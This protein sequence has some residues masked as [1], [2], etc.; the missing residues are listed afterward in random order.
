MVLTQDLI[1]FQKMSRLLQ[2]LDGK[3]RIAVVG[4]EGIP[5]GLDK[6]MRLLENRFGQP[7]IV[8]KACVDA[9]MDAQRLPTTIRFERIRRSSEIVVRN[10]VFNQRFG[11]D[12]HE[13][14]GADESKTSDN[15]SGD[16]ERERSTNSRT[17]TES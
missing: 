3:V 8:T 12:E 17:K 14:P 2:F 10:L 5:G 9:M 11:R 7:H 4:F 16:V 15:S 1:E 13:Q 6:A